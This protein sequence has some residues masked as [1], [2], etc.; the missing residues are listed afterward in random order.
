MDPVQVKNRLKIVELT[1]RAKAIHL[2]SSLSAVDI[3]EAIYEVKKPDEKF[4]LSAGHSAPA[5]YAVLEEHGFLKNPSIEELSVHPTRNALSGIDLSTGSL[6]QGLPIAVGMAL[7]NRNKKVYCCISD[8]ECA[9]GSIYEALRAGVENNLVNLIVIVNANG[10]SAYGKVEPARLAQIF[11]GFGWRV[12]SVNGHSLKILKNVLNSKKS[13][14][15]IIMAR[16]RVD[17]LPFLRGV[18]A[19]YYKMTESDY[20]Q[21][22]KKWS[23]S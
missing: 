19:H 4:I 20:Q 15:T 5:L 2:G 23:K 14:P 7:A 16:T 9:E 1:H 10:Y 13:K 8:G 12:V 11:R 21:A 6:G 18:D 17:Q 22:I 3:I